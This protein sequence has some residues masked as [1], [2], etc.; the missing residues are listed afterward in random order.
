MSNEPMNKDARDEILKRALE[1]RILRELERIPDL[2]SSIPADF[3]ARM[4]ARVP[5]RRD[6]SVT[7]ARYGRSVMWV[8]LAAL[9]IVLPVLAWIGFGRSA[10]D[11]AIEWCL[12]TQFLGIAVWMA[13]YRRREG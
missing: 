5:A 6:V 13:I 9:V 7:P 4:A 10:L 2:S 12:C 8:S 11:V 3:A 1:E